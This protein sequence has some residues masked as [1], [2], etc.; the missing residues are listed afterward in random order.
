LSRFSPPSDSADIKNYVLASDDP[1]DKTVVYGAPWGGRREIRGTIPKNRDEF[2]VKASMP[3]P[4]K[5]LGTEFKEGLDREGII[6]SG[7]VKMAKAGTG[8]MI[9]FENNSPPLSDIVKVLNHKSVNLIAECL[10]K[11]V[12]FEKNGVGSTAAGVK[13]I[14]D[15]WA[16]KGIDIRGMF[17]DD[18]SGLSR[19]NAISPRQVAE[20]LE[21]LKTRSPVSSAFENSLPTAGEGTLSVFDPNKF[22]DRCLRCKSGSMTR[23]RSFAGYL[24]TVSGKDL[25]FVMMANNFSM[26]QN[27]LINKMEDLLTTM[28]EKY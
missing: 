27:N 10:V 12:A 19:S 21:Y 15:F 18:G 17:L 2:E 14:S 1:A 20:I 3:E 25:V 9:I 22:P 24:K 6:V 23:V 16:D 7:G 13:I 5:V 4:E 11:Q 8:A 28:R 26:S